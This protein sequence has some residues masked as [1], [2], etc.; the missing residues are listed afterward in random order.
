M[1]RPGSGHGVLPPSCLLR[2]STQHPV[3]PVA[4]AS[5]LGVTLHLSL[6]HPCGSPRQTVPA[7]CKSSQNAHFSPRP[8]AA[9]NPPHLLPGSCRASYLVHRFLRVS[10]RLLPTRDP[11]DSHVRTGDP[12]VWR[13]APPLPTAHGAVPCLLPS[14]AGSPVRLFKRGAPS[15]QGNGELP[16]F[17][18]VLAPRSPAQVT[19]LEHA[20]QNHTPAPASP[21]PHRP[22][23]RGSAVWSSGISGVASHPGTPPLSRPAWAPSAL[24]ASLGARR[25]G[26][27]RPTDL[28]PRVERGGCPCRLGGRPLQ[29]DGSA[30]SQLL[31]PR[32]PPGGLP[33]PAGAPQP[34]PGH[35]GLRQRHR[36]LLLS[37]ANATVLY[38]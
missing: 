26:A 32:T 28:T 5:I 35:R 25:A 18:Q 4:Q 10:P 8:P 38:S 9:P 22:T 13:P 21:P 30:A 11:A 23:H 34:G 15:L 19:C 37:C 27:V 33:G 14:P 6:P 36:P 7:L 24:P 17:L 1:A 12:P 2:L 3:F 31:L 29:G 20:T 16:H